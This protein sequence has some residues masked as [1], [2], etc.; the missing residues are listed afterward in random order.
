MKKLFFTVFVAL[1]IV[2]APASAQASNVS[3]NLTGDD[4]YQLFLSTDDS[5]Q[6]TLIGSSNGFPSGA[7]DWVDS[8]SFIFGLNP[9]VTNY[10]HIFAYDDERVI[11]SILGN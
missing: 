9:G 11:S 4:H 8:E 6:G 10:L 3:T 2:A 1:I 7:Y 5:V